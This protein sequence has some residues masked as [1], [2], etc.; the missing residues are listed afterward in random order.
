MVTKGANRL[1]RP[2]KEGLEHAALTMAVGI[3]TDRIKRLSQADRD[4]LYE[5]VKGL[6]AAETCEERESIATAMLDILDQEGVQV[7]EMELED[8]PPG[9]GLQTWL[10]Y[11][12]GRIR[13]L[14]KVAHLTQ[15][16]LAAKAGLPQSHISR[17]EGA[18]HSP[19]GATLE[20]IAVALGVPV[21]QF[22]PSA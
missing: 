17:L 6:G 13:E 21:S 12:S 8:S 1:T 16:E 3:V 15:D 22:D 5:L 4:D 14:R 11:V 2:P 9:P 7:R 18:K 20:K 10:D 19:S